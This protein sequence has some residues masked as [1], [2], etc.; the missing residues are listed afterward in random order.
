[1][2]AGVR[3][4][5]IHLSFKFSDVVYTL[6]YAHRGGVNQKRSKLKR[7]VFHRSIYHV[8][9]NSDNYDICYKHG[10]TEL[11]LLPHRNAGHRRMLYMPR[12]V[13]TLLTLP[14]QS[15]TNESEVIANM[16]DSAARV[17]SVEAREY[18]NMARGAPTAGN[19]EAAASA[20]TDDSGFS[21]KSVEAREYANT[22]DNVLGASNAEAP[23]SVNTCEF[24]AGASSAE[25]VRSVST[26]DSAHFA[27][28]V[29]E[30]VSASTDMHA[31]AARSAYQSKR[32][33]SPNI[34][35]SCASRRRFLPRAAGPAFSS[36][37][38]AT[39]RSRHASRRS[40]FPCF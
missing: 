16:G 38:G 24:A 9:V 13:T 6:H 36:V 30:L 5:V 39:L 19:A 37:R 21:A 2:D 29:A 1:M 31:T 7:K 8:I 40:W 3:D 14:S 28:N 26:E 35:A 25:V 12:Q 17:S 22:T 20:S 27:K 32:C 33:S 34:S 11:C 4:V 15:S 23:A 10:F 18:A